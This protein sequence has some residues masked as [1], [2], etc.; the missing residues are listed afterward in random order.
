MIDVSVPETKNFSPGTYVFFE[1]IYRVENGYG[2]DNKKVIIAAHEDASS[3][4]QRFEILGKHL[5]VK[6]INNNKTYYNVEVEAGKSINNDNLTDQSMPEDPKKEGYKFAGWNTKADGT[7]ATFTGDTVVN[8][9]MTVY[10]VYN[11]KWTELNNT[12]V[13]KVK[14]ATIAV[15]D[16]LDLKSLVA[17]AEDKEDGNLIDKV[18]VVNDGGFDNMKAGKYT[19]TYKVTDKDGASAI[20]KAVVT[21]NPKAAVINNI[22]VLKVKDATI[23][24]GDELD[25]KSL[26]VSAEDKED[27]NLMDKVIIVD[28]GGFDNMKA[29]KY[30]VTYKVTDKDGASATAQALVTVNPKADSKDNPKEHPDNKAKVE[31]KQESSRILTGDENTP[32]IYGAM[33]LLSLSLLGF[34]FARRK[35]EK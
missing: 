1:K 35:L 15:G 5:N 8:E 16:K 11:K 14:D 27:G 6:F 13:L 32:F 23:A 4:N 17:S 10:A 9:D 33:I 31:D 21:V 20:A 3:E 28:D 34:V 19:V 22:P 12:P 18:Q 24:V 2:S 30:T 29:G 26:V 7:G 25:L